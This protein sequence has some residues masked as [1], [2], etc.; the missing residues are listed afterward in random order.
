MN[1]IIQHH[2]RLAYQI[3]ATLGWEEIHPSVAFPAI[4]R[5]MRNYI[6]MVAIATLLPKELIEPTLESTLSQ[7]S[8]TFLLNLNK[9]V[10]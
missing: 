2:M 10:L 4:D 5:I 3:R 7:K 9:I 8:Q 6:T 1:S